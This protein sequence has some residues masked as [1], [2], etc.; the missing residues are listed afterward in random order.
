[1]TGVRDTGS[2]RVS[3]HGSFGGLHFGP[4]IFLVLIFASIR[5]SLSLEIQN[6]PPGSHPEGVKS[7]C[8]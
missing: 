4:G 1:M 3:R 2:S 6:S 7:R 8:C 5:S